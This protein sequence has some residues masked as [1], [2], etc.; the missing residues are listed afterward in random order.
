ME[1]YIII[2][3]FIFVTIV[4][5]VVGTTLT[6]TADKLADLTGLGEAVFG[7]IFLG[8]ITSLPGIVT[9]VVAAYQG[10][11]QLAISNAIGG[12]A[13][14]TLFLAIADISYKKINLEHAAA[15]FANLMQGVLLLGLLALVIIGMSGPE[16]SIVNMHPFSLLI[17]VFYIAGTFLI[18]R[19]KE[20]PMWNPRIT[21]VTVKDVPEKR[22]KKLSLKKV[23]IQFIILAIIVVCAGYAVAHLGI[24]IANKSG[25]S[26]TIIGAIFT[27]IATSLPELFVSIAAVR[28]K[29]LTL[30]V[31]NIIGGNSFDVLFVAFADMAYNK[32]SILHA[33]TGAQSYIIGLTMLMVGT[34][35]MGLLHREKKGIGTIGWESL[36]IIILYF[37]GMMF[38]FLA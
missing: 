13:A 8:G 25:L 34:I 18:S 17:I 11:P 38:L 20:K 36:M 21:G 24:A 31:G 33:I 2:L 28:Q 9:S 15:S 29:A 6:R 19:A 3:L 35:I 4:I 14:Q 16:L 27:A 26:E 37:G 7:A 30:S 12:I 1:L 23:L 32:G 5:G 22:N 10:H